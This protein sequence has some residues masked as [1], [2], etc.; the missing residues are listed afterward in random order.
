MIFY[1]SIPLFAFLVVLSPV[2]SRIWLG[3]IDSTFLLLVA[4]LAAGWLVNIL[5]NPAYVIALGTGDLR[6]V[7]LGCFSTLSLNAILGF[8]GGKFLGGMAV[9]GA[10]VLSLIFGYL[11][12]L[13]SYHLA[14]RIS[15][16]NLWPARSLLLVL[17]SLAGVAVFFPYFHSSRTRLLASIPTASAILAA[18]LLMVVIPMWFHPMR[19]RLLQWIASRLP[20]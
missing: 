8:F 2:V 19:R 4:L 20:A 12:I 3:R 5:C 15:F 6:W 7:T 17:A 18:A 16:A 9:V 10:A 14:N 13:F 11:V 1:L